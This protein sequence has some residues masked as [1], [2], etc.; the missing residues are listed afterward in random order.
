VNTR[1]YYVYVIESKNDSGRS[2][3]YVGQTAH[4]PEVRLHQ[5]VSGKAY[6]DEGCKHRHYVKG[7]RA[8]LRPEFY[9][10]YNPLHSRR[11]AEAVEKWLAHKLRVRGY[12]VK[13]GH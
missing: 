12:S 10:R 2:T 6:C 7:T 1:L 11:E 13:G 9:S 4:S 5:H 8:R 3:F